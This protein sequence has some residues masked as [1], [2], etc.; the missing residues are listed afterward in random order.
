ME[1]DVDRG[2]AAGRLGSLG[3]ERLRGQ[4]WQFWLAGAGVV[5]VVVGC[6]GPW[7]DRTF[8]PFPYGFQTDDG[9]A[10]ILVSVGAGALLW[11]YTASRAIPTLLFAALVGAFMMACGALTIDSVEASSGP[12]SVF[13][14]AID[15]D[16]QDHT[17]ILDSWGLIL[18]VVGGLMTMIGAGLLALERAGHPQRPA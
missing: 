9:K 2:R 11:R 5:I 1:G 3:L 13:G 10:L 18:V 4:P 14:D 16:V 8:N 7:T 6:L 12:G 15:T 17:S